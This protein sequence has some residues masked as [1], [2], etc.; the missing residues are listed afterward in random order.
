MFSQEKAEAGVKTDE[1]GLKF[2]HR[3]LSEELLPTSQEPSV[4]LRRARATRVV[5]VLKSD[6]HKFRFIYLIKRSNVAAILQ[7]YKKNKNSPK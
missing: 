7:R 2:T 1:E 3:K 4:S 5:T 6:L